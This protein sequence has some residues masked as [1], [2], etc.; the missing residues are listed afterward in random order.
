VA[1]TA[2]KLGK[3]VKATGL[4]TP[5]SLAASRVKLSVQV[6]KSATWASVKTASA[7]TTATDAYAWIHRPAR[8]AL[9]PHEGLDRRA[10]RA[11]GRQDEVGRV[12]REV[13]G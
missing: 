7:T 10:G 2:L 13:E 1:L 6:R 3:Y 8:Q 9:V 5:T 11:H 4:L 12:R